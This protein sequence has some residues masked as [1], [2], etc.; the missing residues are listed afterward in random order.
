MTNEVILAY[1]T[2]SWHLKWTCGV[3]NVQDTKLARSV[4]ENCK[5]NM[6]AHTSNADYDTT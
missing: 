2:T 1:L 5:K 6:H 4:L 3:S